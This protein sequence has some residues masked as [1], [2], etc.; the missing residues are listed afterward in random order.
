MRLSLVQT[1]DSC[2]ESRTT[3][4]ETQDGIMISR[5]N[6]AVGRNSSCHQEILE[7][8]G[9]AQVNVRSLNSSRRK[10]ERK[11]NT[12]LSYRDYASD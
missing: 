1:D 5:N 10:T 11:G 3:E 12:L 6:L 9:N 2:E 7:E 8:A 4:R